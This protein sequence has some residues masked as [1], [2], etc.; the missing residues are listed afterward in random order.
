[1][2]SDFVEKINTFKKK[3]LDGP[4]SI[5]IVCNCCLYIRSVIDFKEKKCNIFVE[6][7]YT[8]V[9]SFDCKLYVRR[10]CDLKLKKGKIPCQPVCNKLVVSCLPE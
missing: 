8:D 4:N 10:T 2:N 1:M 3:I 6:V 7:L 5:C 9:K